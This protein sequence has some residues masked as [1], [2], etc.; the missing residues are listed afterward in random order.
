MEPL[1]NRKA[2]RFSLCWVKF[3]LAGETRFQHTTISRTQVLSLHILTY[4]KSETGLSLSEFSC[5]QANPKQLL[6][7]QAQNIY[8]HCGYLTRL[9]S[10][11]LNPDEDGSSDKAN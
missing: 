2:F 4:W 6:K 11:Q 7:K 1:I 8:D 10:A 3:C 9:C 5:N